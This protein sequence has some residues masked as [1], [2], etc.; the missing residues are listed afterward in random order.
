MTVTPRGGELTIRAVR[1]MFV[2]VLE[3]L[4]SNSVYWLGIYGKKK[5]DYQPAIDVHIDVRRRTI[6]SQTMGLESRLTELMT[7]FSRL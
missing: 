3:N 7:F 5:T 1:G 4:I 6:S 2:Q